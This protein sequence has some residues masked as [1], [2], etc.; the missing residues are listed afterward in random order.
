M[1]RSSLRFALAALLCGPLSAVA[2][3]PPTFSFETVVFPNDTFTQLLGINSDR[4]IAGYHG[5]DVN[6]GFLLTLPNQFTDEN[7]TNSAQTQVIGINKAGDTDGFYVD[8]GGTT[9]GF[10][11][12][13]GTFTTVDFPGTNFN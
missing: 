13:N 11:K 5:M 2:M 7:F 8:E 4:Q 9:H 10:L 3:N 1:K 12:I 6:K